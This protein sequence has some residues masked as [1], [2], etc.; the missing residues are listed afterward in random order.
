MKP[1][2]RKIRVAVLESDPVRFLGMRAIFSTEPD[3]QLRAATVATML[4]ERKDDVVLLAVD[5]GAA[6]YAAMSALKAVRPTIRIIV[7]GPGNEDENILRAI[8]AGAKG[9]LSEEAS[10][11]E[12]KKA[13]REVESGSV[14]L[15]AR[16][17]ASF[18]ERATV[19]ARRVQP[20]IDARISHREREVLQL[21]VAGCS[22]REIA[23]ELGIIERTVKAHVGQ[24]LRKVGVSNRI[25]L[26]VHAVT[27]SLL[28]LQPELPR[29][30]PP[31]QN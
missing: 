29:N 24:L 31:T 17:V 6:F 28:H 5:R 18:I 19:S 15:P 12:Y 10:P 3:I 25:A 4:H 23:K 13:L 9:Y 26:S 14:W 7:T 8:S 2:P 11:G 21:L 16:V 27:H 20:Q 30:L 1:P 22:N